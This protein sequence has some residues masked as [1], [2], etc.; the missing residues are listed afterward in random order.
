MKDATTPTATAE[1]RAVLLLRVSSD[2]QVNKDYDAEGLSLPAQRDACA[3]LAEQLGATV[4][5]EYVEPGTSGGF[6]HKR[7]VFQAMLA[8]IEDEGDIDFVIVWSI[9]RFAR[10]QEDH[11]TAKGL[12]TRA[13]AS[14]VSVKERIGGTGSGDVVLEGVLA[15]VAHGRRIEI[16]EDVRRGIRQKAKVGG[17][18]FRAPLG[19]VNVRKIVSYRLC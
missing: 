5:D 7:K 16:A 10:N 18:P 19:Y 11:W 4:V 12:I 14:L 15:A 2:G 3:R 9:S 6:M 1:K 13:G 17:T 8:R